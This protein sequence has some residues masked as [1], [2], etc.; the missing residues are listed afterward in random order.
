MHDIGPASTAGLLTSNM[1]LGQ[2][3]SLRE[4]FLRLSGSTNMNPLRSVLTQSEKDRVAV[5][6]FNVATLVMLKAAL[7]AAAETHKRPPCDSMI[8]RLNP[9]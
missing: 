2:L 9:Q 3:G 7:S 5:G 8:D 4:K 1:Q 6:H